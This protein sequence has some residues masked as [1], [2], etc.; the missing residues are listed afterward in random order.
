MFY[1]YFQKSIFEELSIKFS[2]FLVVSLHV[3]GEGGGLAGGVQ[4]HLAGGQHHGVGDWLRLP[5]LHE[6]IDDGEVAGGEEEEASR[7]ECWVEEAD[8]HQLQVE[9]VDDQ[10]GVSCAVPALEPPAY[11]SELLVETETVQLGRVAASLN[12]F[13]LKNLN[14]GKIME[15]IFICYFKIF[16][17][18]VN[19][20]S[21][22]TFTLGKS[23][24]CP[25]RL[26]VAVGL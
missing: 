5:P 6:D 18:K 25:D 13:D 22:R 23:L 19:L 20:R 2:P 7:D 9:A 1:F 15:S 8:L 10:L 14:F 12:T 3:E 21:S 16:L 17:Q 4:H 24:A 11:S 26:L